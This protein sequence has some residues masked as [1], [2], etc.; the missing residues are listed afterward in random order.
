MGGL[1]NSETLIIVLVDV[2]ITSA[3]TLLVSRLLH[4]RRPIVTCLAAGLLIPLLLI[5]LAVVVTSAPNPGH[6]DAPGMLMVVAIYGA[7]AATPVGL[8]ASAATL[9]IAARLRRSRQPARP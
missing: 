6:R 3:V 4:G 1:L 5:L 9:A 2:A 8:A 7:A